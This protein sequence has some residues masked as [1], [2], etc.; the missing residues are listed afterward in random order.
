V[1]PV[2]LAATSTENAPA[3]APETSRPVSARPAREAR[4]REQRAAH[5]AR[6]R[7][8]P[9]TYPIREFLAWRR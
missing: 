7:V 8:R 4:V 5:P 6:K 1:Q 9:A 3:I 2:G